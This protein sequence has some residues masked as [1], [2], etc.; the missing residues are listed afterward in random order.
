M[1]NEPRHDK[2]DKVE[3]AHSD[4]SDQPRHPLNQTR[5]FAVHVQ[6]AKIF[7]HP[8]GEQRRQCSVSTAIK[9]D[10]SFRM[11]HLPRCRFCRSRLSSSVQASTQ[12]L[13]LS[14]RYSDRK[15]YI[16]DAYPCIIARALMSYR[17]TS[18]KWP[19]KM[20]EKII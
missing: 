10:L 2:T 19:G 12:S 15:H 6:V 14:A 1:N 20:T 3:C 8:L 13:A 17:A 9:A 4:D 18:S 11:A 5:V 16:R 7:N